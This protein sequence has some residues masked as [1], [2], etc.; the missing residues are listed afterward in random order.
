MINV[1]D[2]DRKTMCDLFFC[3]VT[4]PDERECVGQ[5]HEY[6]HYIKEIFQKNKKLNLNHL[7]DTVLVLQ[8]E[9]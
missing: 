1:L 7:Y 6:P 9:K 3:L 8:T 4:R 2:N 5:L